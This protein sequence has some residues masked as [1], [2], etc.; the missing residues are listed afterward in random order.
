MVDQV[1]A[2]WW[3]GGGLTD[4]G[5]LALAMLPG[6]ALLVATARALRP[7][8][9][10]PTAALFASGDLSLAVYEELHAVLVPAGD[11]L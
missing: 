9:F 10:D 4:L 6:V 5:R 8:A 2:N 1:A 11:G 7:P 3:M